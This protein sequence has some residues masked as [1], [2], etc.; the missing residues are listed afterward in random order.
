[1]G[2][3]SETVELYLDSLGE[4]PSARHQR[5][6]R[7]ALSIMQEELSNVQPRSQEHSF[8]VQRLQER[9]RKRARLGQPGLDVKAV[10]DFE[11]VNRRVGGL[12]PTM[13]PFVEHNARLF[14]YEAFERYNKRFDPELIQ[15]PYDYRHMY[16]MW[17]FGPGASNGVQGSHTADK[18]HQPM[19]CTAP[20]VPL[21]R[22]LRLN[23]AYF[24]RYDNA[25]NSGVTEVE[26]S[27]LAT[28]PKNETTERTIAIEPSGNMA[29]QLGLGCYIEDVLRSIG[30]DIRNQQPKNKVLAWVGSITDEFATIDMSSASDMFHP[31]LVR[32]LLPPGMYDAMI[33]IRSPRTQLPDK[34]WV[35]LEMMSTMGNGFTFP[36]MTLIFVALIYAV[37]LRKGGPKRYIDWNRT[38]V[39]GD[40]IIVPKSEVSELIDVLQGC[41]FLINHEKSYLSGPFRESCGGDYFNGHDVT[42]VYLK[43][44][45]TNSQVYTSIN[46]VFEWCGKQNIILPNTL[47]YLKGCLRGEAFFVPEWHGNDAGIRTAQVLA[48]RY[49]HLQAVAVAVKLTKSQVGYAMPLI[50]GG[51]VSQRKSD[52]VFVPR[53]RRPKYKVRKSRL[54][55]GYLDGRDPFTRSDQVSSFVETFSFI[56]QEDELT[57]CP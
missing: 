21:I 44:L 37:R 34:R 49:K 45:S 11:T 7:E 13:D 53:P 27:R 35:H 22:R 24:S 42:P 19:S 6:L 33:R 2:K 9:M 31:K 10:S 41:G 14:V 46:G 3:S 1:M 36:M 5:R 12:V 38:C 55:S 30:L 39:F 48:R 23:N 51:Y 26:G 25:V 15:T 29:L 17:R 40:D 16:S 54:P 43:Q 32:K 50:C 56:L 28:V 20:S 18:I 8:A 57:T 4:K 52:F 47:R